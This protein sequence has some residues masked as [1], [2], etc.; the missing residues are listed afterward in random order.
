LILGANGQVARVVTALFLK[1]P[2]VDLT[3]FLLR[4]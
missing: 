2:E 4:T 1:Q 3:L